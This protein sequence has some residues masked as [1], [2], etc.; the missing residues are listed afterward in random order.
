[1]RNLSIE[2]IFSLYSIFNGTIIPL[3]NLF[4]VVEFT[5]IIGIRFFKILIKY[6]EQIIIL[7]LIILLLFIF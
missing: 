5:S 7:Y 4:T 1:M 3:N 6:L 2:I